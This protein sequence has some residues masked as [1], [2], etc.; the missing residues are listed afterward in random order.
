VIDPPPEALRPQSRASRDTASY[1][2]VTPT[3]QDG[4][5]SRLGRP[6]L[7][8]SS[9]SDH[10]PFGPR[11][12]SPLPLLSP[13]STIN[14][15]PALDMDFL[16]DDADAKSSHSHTSSLPVVLDAQSPQPR[17]PLPRSRPMQFDRTN[18]ME[19]T[20]KAAAANT[21]V[22]SKGSAIG[23]LLIKKKTSLREEPSPTKRYP[24]IEL[25]LIKPLPRTEALSRPAFKQL[26]SAGSEPLRSGD[27]Q[28]DAEARVRRLAEATKLD[29]GLLSLFSLVCVTHDIHRST[30]PEGL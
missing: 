28:P 24:G 4:P 6:L 22:E 19:A 17:S 16:S 15:L 8:S 1:R 14:P 12:P 10:R 25:P 29:V 2:S 27:D 18:S 23:P 13:T 20:P 21:S 7:A 3:P 9:S 30:L 26:R 5:D 11:S